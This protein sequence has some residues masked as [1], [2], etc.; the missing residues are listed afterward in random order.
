MKYKAPAYSEICKLRH[1][2][3]A[4]YGYHF[5]FYTDFDYSVL[6]K[7]TW[8]H[9]RG[10]GEDHITMNDAIIM[11]DTETSKKSI[12]EHNHVVA[13]TISIRALHVNVCT[14]YGRKPSEYI[15]CINR[16]LEA[17]PGDRTIIYFHNYSYDYVFLRKYMFDAWGYPLRCLNTKPHYPIS[18]EFENGLIIRDSLILAQR[19]LDKWAKDMAAE[20]QKAVGSWD[21]TKLR[22]QTTQLNDQELQYIEHDTLAGVE[23]LDAMLINLNKKISTIPYT[24]TGIPREHVRKLAKANRGRE[25]WQKIVMSFDDYIFS[26]SVYHG[27]YVHANRD[28]IG[29]INPAIC[30]DFASSY[31]FIMISE[32]FPMEAFTFLGNVNLDDLLQQI[33]NYAFMFRLILINPR[34]KESAVMP[35]LQFYKCDTKINAVQDN[36]RILKA[37]YIAINI[38]EQDLLILL[39]QYDYDHLYITQCRAARKDYLPRWF[40][41]YVYECFR[42]KTML[43]GGDPVAYAMA[44]AIVNSLYGM[45]VQ[46]CIQDDLRECYYNEDDEHLDGDYCISGEDPKELYQKY[47]DNNNNVLPYQWGIW[48]TAYAFKNL[49]DLGSC[50]A[51]EG[52]WLYSDTDSCY[53]TA[54]DQSKV[55]AYNDRCKNKLIANNYGPVIKDGREYWLGV[56]ELDGEYKEFISQGAK[57]YACRTMDGKIKITVAG[58]PKSGAK[59]LNDDLH[60]FRPGLVF[61]GKTTGKLLHKYIYVDKPYIDNDGNETADSVDLSSCDY[62]LGTVNAIKW[63]DL[64]AEEINIQVYEND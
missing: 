9:Y 38:T 4:A 47:L 7:I 5:Q 63:E 41:D 2:W 59:C 61:D 53:A 10:Y 62:L 31:P 22:N 52:L 57:R 55:D 37:D 15:D 26:E 50:V 44:K 56:A 13:W 39:D 16:I 3:L 48:V 12:S 20:H 35:A 24:A 64:E 58:V 28:E 19:S 14:L 60:N 8:V 23:C 1:D 45:C 30:Y 27:G 17:M 51:S 40:T 25:L 46:K 6:S 36:G 43:K 21:Y 18:M 29:W 34:K 32:K 33:D 54:W 49:F 11:A 42:N